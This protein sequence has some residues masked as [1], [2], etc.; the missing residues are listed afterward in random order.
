MKGE[1]SFVGYDVWA[2]AGAGGVAEHFRREESV[3]D[4]SDFVQ[5]RMDPEV[6]SRL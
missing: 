5:R 6:K 1:V 3:E 4:L 2:D